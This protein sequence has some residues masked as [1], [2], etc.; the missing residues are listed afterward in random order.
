[1]MIVGIT[2]E[3]FAK[4]LSEREVVP[5]V[6]SIIEQLRRYQGGGANVHSASNARSYLE[7]LVENIEGGTIK[8]RT[9]AELKSEL[10]YPA[11]RFRFLYDAFIRGTYTL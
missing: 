10:G 3:D 8:S 7:S 1:M 2:A 9:F 5:T 6:T 11:E 4:Q